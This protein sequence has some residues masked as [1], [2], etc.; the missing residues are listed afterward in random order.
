MDATASHYTKDRSCHGQ[1]GVRIL[2]MSER[3]KGGGSSWPPPSKVW[4]PDLSRQRCVVDKAELSENI[5]NFSEH[6]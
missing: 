5:M 1:N 2:V 4:P 6:F 3:G